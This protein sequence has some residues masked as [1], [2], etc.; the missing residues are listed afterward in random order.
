AVAFVIAQGAA[1]G[2]FPELLAGGDV[3]SED[4]LPAAE[5][6]LGVQA[7]ADHG[8][9]GIAFAEALRLPDKARSAGGAPAG[10]GRF[11]GFPRRVWAPATEASRPPKLS[12]RGRERSEEQIGTCRKSNAARHAAQRG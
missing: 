11:R 3:E 12:R 2:C 7:I 9:R 6:P 5:L 8:E 4:E 10:A 1:G